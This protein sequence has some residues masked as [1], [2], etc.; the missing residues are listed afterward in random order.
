MTK[1]FADNFMKA[2]ADTFQGIVLPGSHNNTDVRVSLGCRHI[3]FVQKI[4]VLGV[5]IDE[6][7]N[8]NE[9]V[10]RICSKASTQICAL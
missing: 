1:W 4:D 8:F 2:N 7:L 9:H 10:H 6:K 3:A 5:C